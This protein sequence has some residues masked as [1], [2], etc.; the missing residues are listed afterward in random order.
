[1]GDDEGE[2]DFAFAALEDGARSEPLIACP[3]RLMSHSRLP[4]SINSP[5]GCLFSHSKNGYPIW[6]IFFDKTKF[7]N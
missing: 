2:A 1:M 7:V 6:G 4:Y 3:F 5:L